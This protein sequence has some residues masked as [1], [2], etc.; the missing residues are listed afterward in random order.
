MDLLNSKLNHLFEMYYW[1]IQNY[2]FSVFA[3]IM[4]M[5]LNPS[6]DDKTLANDVR[7]VSSGFEY[8][9]LIFIMVLGLV[10]KVV[11]LDEE[12]NSESNGDI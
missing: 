12:L 5:R 3:P 10:L 1:L 6:T 2:L 4:N 9:L 7:K 11:G 8:F